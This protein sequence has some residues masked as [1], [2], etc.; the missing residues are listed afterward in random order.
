[1]RAGRLRHRVTIQEFVKLSEDGI[2]GSINEWI[3]VATVWARVI[4]LNGRE[5][6][7]AQQIMPE[8]THRVEMRYK[9][10][11]NSK[12]RLLHRGRVLDNISIKNIDELNKEI[13]LLCREVG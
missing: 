11:L 1:M 6:V 8:T 13:H 3:N 12:M 7:I 5:L 2:G 9:G 10:G 4:P